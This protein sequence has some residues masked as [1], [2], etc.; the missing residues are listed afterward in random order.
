MGCRCTRLLDDGVSHATVIV[1]RSDGGGFVPLFM[2]AAW[3]RSRS[4]TAGRFK[5]EP[6]TG[7]LRSVV[8]GV[9]I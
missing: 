1:R 9:I 2:S 4:A 5:A 6:A 7:A 8:A 3:L